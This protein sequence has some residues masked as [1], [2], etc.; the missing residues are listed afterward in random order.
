[1]KLKMTIAA[2]FV[3]ASPSLAFAMG[4]N[5]GSH[6]TQQAAMSCAEGLMLDIETNTCVP[7]TTG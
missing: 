3:M 4:C 1:M 6:A 7:L 5:G 2:I